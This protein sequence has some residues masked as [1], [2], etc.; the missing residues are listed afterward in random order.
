MCVYHT[1]SRIVWYFSFNL[2]LW[3]KS[4]QIDSS[5]FVFPR[6]SNMMRKVMCAILEASLLLMLFSCTQHRLC[7]Y[8]INSQ[9][10]R[11][12]CSFSRNIVYLKLFIKVTFHKVAKVPFSCILMFL[13]T[14]LTHR[15]RCMFL[16][17]LCLQY[18]CTIQNYFLEY[19]HS[20]LWKLL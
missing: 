11:L 7:Q 18:R 2:R 5:L 17:L 14:M 1:D 16:C 20:V 3:K 15:T 4:E 19:T 10:I 6:M 13:D 12:S 9:T 8:L